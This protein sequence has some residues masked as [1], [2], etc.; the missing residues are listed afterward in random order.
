LGGLTRPPF[1]AKLTRMSISDELEKLHNLHARGAIT[2]EEFLA[3]KARLLAEGTSPEQGF[4]P[5][6]NMPT[7]NDPHDFARKCCNV[8]GGEQSW[9]MLIHLSNY[10]SMITAG[11]GIVAPILMWVFVKDY[12]PFVDQ[13]GRNVINAMISY[14]IYTLVLVIL[15]AA[16]LVVLVGFVFLLLAGLLAILMLIFPAIGAIKASSGEAWR[17]PFTIDFIRP[18][19]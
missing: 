4:A 3:A 14:F 5:H 16:L 13:N 18:R 12:S 17:Y 2:E 9:A 1:F 7:H 6:G 11:L 10:L 15:G 8:V 19:Q